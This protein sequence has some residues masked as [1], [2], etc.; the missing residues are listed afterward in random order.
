LILMSA[1]IE[2]LDVKDEE[3]DLDLDRLRLDTKK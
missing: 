1:D 3:V 2:E